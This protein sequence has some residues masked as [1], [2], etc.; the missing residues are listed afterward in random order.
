MQKTHTNSIII[1]YSP[2][3]LETW[4]YAK[5][6]Q[7]GRYTLWVNQDLPFNMGRRIRVDNRLKEEEEALLYI[8]TGEQSGGSEVY[9]LIRPAWDPEAFASGMNY[10]LKD[11]GDNQRREL[12]RNITTNYRK[13]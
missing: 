13:E 11:L 12:I 3:A 1:S 5:E 4:G 8:K 6:A 9:F 2:I 7:R 10:L